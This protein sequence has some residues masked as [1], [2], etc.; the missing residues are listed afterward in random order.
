LV[1]S[2]VGA[3]LCLW[4]LSL[5]GRLKGI[6]EYDD[7]VYLGAALRL[8]SGDAP[9][10]DF[11]FVQPPGIVVMMAPLALLAKGV[12]S[13]TSLA[14]ARVVTGL[15]AGINA[16]LVAWLVRARGRVAMAV[17]GLGL[18]LFPLGVVADHTLLLEPYLVLLVVAGSVVA[19]GDPHP[20]TQRLVVAGAL[21]GLGGA[22]KLWAIF[23]FMAL[24]ACEGARSRWRAGWLVGGAALGFGAICL[25]FAA[26]GPSRFVHQV[27]LDQLG[28]D[29]SG[30]NAVSVG[31]RLMELTGLSGIRAVPPSPLVAL[32]LL[33]V[34]AC[35]ALVVGCWG[36]G[37]GR[38]RIVDTYLVVAAGVSVAGL[39]GA[40]DFYGHYA[41]FTAPLLA[42]VAGSTVAGLAG[43][44]E[45]GW[46]ERWR[47]GAH[48]SGSI[49]RVAPL[50]LGL[51]LVALVGVNDVVYDLGYLPASL[52]ASSGAII[53]PGPAIARVVPPGACVVFDD[54]VLA[55]EADR[56]V[57]SRSP[58]PSVVDPYGMWMVDG[59]GHSPPS[60][61][62]YPAD[63][64][65]TWR[66]NMA[67]ADDVVL[68]SANSGY[69]PWT[70]SLRAYLHDHF[71]AVLVEKDAVVYARR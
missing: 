4:Q 47:R 2:L 61:P 40:P 48:R 68:T 33:G 18:G 43:L 57:S 41:Y 59:H 37:R 8:V 17:A 23:P 56:F 66:A 44:A 14:V 70:D 42:G 7:G 55:I 5:P 10:R 65:A 69:V 60:P 51:A 11:V 15:V 13:A 64:V 46:G 19:F 36:R 6:T 29:Q 3:G 21:F 31:D 30:L 54:P 27:I 45:G 20:S 26:L 58:C 32:V 52:Q 39:L 22:V 28:R 34:L 16:G 63:L 24:L 1:V 62:P 35:L 12:G 9:Y 67:L 38:W 50:V 53:D 25:P 71:A 49:R